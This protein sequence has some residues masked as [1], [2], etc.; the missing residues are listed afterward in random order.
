[1]HCFHQTNPIAPLAGDFRRVNP[2]RPS[3]AY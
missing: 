2:E 3:Y 1:M